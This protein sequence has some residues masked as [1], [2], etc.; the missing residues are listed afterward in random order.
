NYCLLPDS[1][2][3][4]ETLTVVAAG[5]PVTA[6]NL[7]LFGGVD[8]KKAVAGGNMIRFDVFGWV[9]S[10]DVTS[11]LGIILI[12]WTAAFGGFLL[13]FTPCV[14]PVIP[15]KII[16]LSRAAENRANCMALGLAMSLGVVIFWFGL[17]AVIAAIS[18]FTAMNQ[19]FQY[20]TF[21]IIIGIIIAFM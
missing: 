7:D 18:E 10:L 15:I 16:S 8:T 12:L 2:T 17:G 9:F 19:M 14:L 3:A 6:I 21:T 1:L 20:P 4:Q 11:R 5:Q 13:N